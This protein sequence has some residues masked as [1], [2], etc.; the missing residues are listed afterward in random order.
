MSFA[1]FLSAFQ[2]SER[3][4]QRSWLPEDHGKQSQVTLSSLSGINCSHVLPFPRRFASAPWQFLLMNSLSLF[5]PASS[6]NAVR[7]DSS[8][9]ELLA[10]LWW[11]NSKPQTF[12]KETGK[13][14]IPIWGWEWQSGRDWQLRTGSA[15]LSCAYKGSSQNIKPI[16]KKTEILLEGMEFQHAWQ[17]FL[18]LVPEMLGVPSVPSS[19][20]CNTV[21]PCA[22][23]PQYYHGHE[24][25]F[26]Y[27]CS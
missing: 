20:R 11:T 2:A 19:T 25:V 15:D 10:S 23:N 6:A 5:W 27:S 17:K 22:F 18:L 7:K 1:Y 16:L 14:K 4:V 8:L 3:D 13:W 26:T 12:L 24:H 9:W 21:F